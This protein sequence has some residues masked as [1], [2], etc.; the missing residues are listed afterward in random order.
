LGAAVWALPALAAPP[1]AARHA[2]APAPAAASARPGE[3]DARRRGEIEA[4]QK[5]DAADALKRLFNIDVDW[6]T[7]PLD[8]LIDIRVRAAKAADLQ[9]RLGVSVEWQRY[10]W[11]ELEALRRTLL[12]FEQYRNSDTPTAATLPGQPRPAT[13]YDALVN[14]TFNSSG[15]P[16][17][18]GGAG[19]S[20]DPDG[21]IRPTFRGRV[22]APFVARDPDGVIRPTFAVRPR[23]SSVAVTGDPDGLIAP[24]F[25]PIRRFAPI[26]DTRDLDDLIDP[27]RTQEGRSVPARW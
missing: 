21:I 6:R 10:S 22:A 25:A 8:K 26:G 23:W 27:I 17:A 20:A 5:Q 24:T 16:V 18:R 12:S 3:I 19:R 4:L 7:T 13:G 14:P 11:I 2:A 9:A 15:G 1:A